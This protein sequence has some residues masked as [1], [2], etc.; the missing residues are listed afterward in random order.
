MQSLSSTKLKTFWQSLSD[1]QKQQAS[2]IDTSEIMS[3]LANV[4]NNALLVCKLHPDCKDKDLIV[5]K[6]AKTDNEGI[7]THTFT[8]NLIEKSVLG[9]HLDDLF[10]SFSVFITRQVGRGVGSRGAAKQ[11]DLGAKSSFNVK[12]EKLSDLIQLISNAISA[13]FIEKINE[14]LLQ[15][16]QTPFEM[17]SS[18]VDFS[19]QNLFA[20]L[21]I[22]SYLKKLFDRF[23]SCTFLIA[24]KIHF[25]YCEA[26]GLDPLAPQINEKLDQFFSMMSGFNDGQKPGL[27]FAKTVSQIE[28][29]RAQEEENLLIDDEQSTDNGSDSP[30]E[31]SGNN[32]KEEM[33]FGVPMRSVPL[34]ETYIVYEGCFLGDLEMMFDPSDCFTIEEVDPLQ[35][36]YGD[37]VQENEE[38]NEEGEQEEENYEEIE[39]EHNGYYP[40]QMGYIPQVYPAQYG[41]Y[42]EYYPQATYAGG[43][44]MEGYYQTGGYDNQQQQH[45][46]KKS[47][48]SQSSYGS[49][50]ENFSSQYGGNEGY[51]KFSYYKK[52]APFD[53]RSKLPPRFQRKREGN[54]RV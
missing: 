21:S 3:D 38:N 13:Q 27:L 53:T 26:N 31:V 42:P 45:M 24:R 33:K 43:Y 15:T 25:A 20:D 29:E 44:N 8:L 14:I 35:K 1:S 49:D 22:P 5:W 37:F 30:K 23:A 16:G 12:Q 28:K 6:K 52:K 50:K 2:T 54:F 10:S 7:V 18:L 36:F 40:P 32:Q 47:F 51:D 34:V 46:R 19:S 39:Q 11:P 17:Y 9:K 48:E 41:Y 4:A